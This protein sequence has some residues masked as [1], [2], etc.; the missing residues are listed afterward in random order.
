MVISNLFNQEKTHP[1]K[2]DCFND[3]KFYFIPKRMR[4]GY[5]DQWETRWLQTGTIRVIYKNDY[6]N[7]PGGF[8]REELKEIECCWVDDREDEL[9]NWPWLKRLFLKQRNVA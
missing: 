6:F 9:E 1:K 7:L 3:T 4:L 2:G 5:S 8:F